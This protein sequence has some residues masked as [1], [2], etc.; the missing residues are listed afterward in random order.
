MKL[1]ILL[2]FEILVEISKVTKINAETSTGS[3]GILPHRLDFVT[4]LTMGILIY[5][6]ED[7]EESIVAIDEGILVKVGEEVLICVRQARVGKNLSEL[8]NEIEKKFSNE[9]ERS[10]NVRSALVKMESGFIRRLVE[11]QNE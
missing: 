4:A 6:E 5:E 3:F 10:K 7:K 2:P 1:K 11:F 8:K 9:D